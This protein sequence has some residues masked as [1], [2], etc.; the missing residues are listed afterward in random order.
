MDALIGADHLGEFLKAHGMEIG[1][2]G[3]PVLPRHLVAEVKPITVIKGLASD[4]VQKRG[5]KVS[6]SIEPIFCRPIRLDFNDVIADAHRSVTGSMPT[7]RTRQLA[8]P[9]NVNHN[10]IV[11]P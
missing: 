5:G 4:E 6:E 8:K 11:V 3:I 7:I 10:N 1:R 2:N 9:C